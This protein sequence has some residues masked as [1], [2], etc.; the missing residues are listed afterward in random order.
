MSSPLNLK[1]FIFWILI[2]CIFTNAYPQG[3]D[4]LMS[5]SY[6]P[7]D[8]VSGFLKLNRNTRLFYQQEWFKDKKF[9]SSY[10]DLSTTEIMERITRVVSCD[11][12]LIDSLTIVI[13]PKQAGSYT[14]DPSSS[15]LVSI[16]DPMKYGQSSKAVLQGKVLNGKTGEPLA[17]AIVFVEK[18]NLG[19]TSGAKGVYSIELP[20]GENRLTLKYIGFENKYVNIKLLSDG[21]FDLELFESSVKLDEVQISAQQSDANV[22]R[23]QMSVM[24]FDTKAL[25][26]LPLTLGEKD[27]IKSISLLPGIQSVGEFGTGFNVRGG[28]NDQNLILIEGAPVI[29]SSHLFGL[30]SILNANT[31]SNVTLMKAGI[32]ASFGERSSSILSIDMGPENP[33]RLKVK[34]GIGLINSS[35]NLETPLI[36]KKASLIL[37]GRS[38][39]SNWLLHKIPDIDLINSSANFY[40]INGLLTVKLN[41]KNKIKLFGYLSQDDFSLSNS[42]IY[43]YSNL[44]GSARWTHNFSD[45][46]SSDL[47]ASY[48]QYDYSVAGVDTLKKYDAYQIKSQI[49]YRSLKWNLSY[50]LNNKHDF[51]LGW[52]AILYNVLPGTETPYG[53]ESFVKNL[54]IAPEKALELAL[55]LSDNITISDKLNMEVGIRYSHYSLLGPGNVNVYNNAP[56]LSIASIADTLS[57]SSN[58][59]IKN[60]SGP[61][62]RISFRYVLNSNSSLK[63]SYNRI[64]QYINLVSNTSVATPS[65]VMKLS[66]TYLKPLTMDQLA[67]GYYKN[68]FQNKI[69]ASV[70]IYYKNLN[71]VLE[72][73]DGAKILMNNQIETALL[74]ARGYNYGLEFFIKKNYGKL[75]GWISYTYSRSL[76]K[77]ESDAEADKINMNEAFPSNFDKPNNLVVIGNY[78]ISRRWRFSGT[79]TYN[80]GRPVTLPELKY[81][82]QDYHLIHYSDRNKYRLPDY[83]RLDLSITMDESLR[84]RKRWKGSWTLSVINL[85]GRKNAYSVYYQNDNPMEPD[86]YTS[87]SLYKMYIIGRPFP[88]LT[89]NLSF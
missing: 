71:N 45:R 31:V 13:V 88:T 72:Y 22:Y 62:P 53:P 20:V 21:S 35:L 89:Y 82:Y 49:K 76:R 46:L 83:H 23:T 55:Y 75:N 50:S 32:P 64:N 41:P 56:S 2:S 7:I 73:R 39:Y 81:N 40:D 14:S 17:G 63:L 84:I 4:V 51:D 79:F 54:T 74:N 67:L 52:N 24:K 11:Y 29:N 61:E 27:I 19:T 37:G 65:D 12:F 3:T 5:K 25:K 8:S 33:E 38:S 10:L 42:Y 26:E 70:E 68:F 16:G 80:T 87:G 85:Y 86:T 1:R 44:L 30:I 18:H 9:H 43:D 48:S 36:N 59:R 66:D 47:L 57:F 77:T 60:Y 58:Q 69:E 28:G 34:A 15:G 6:I 78:Q